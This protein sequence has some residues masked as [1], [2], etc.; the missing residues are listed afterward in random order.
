VDEASERVPRF[1]EERFRELYDETVTEA[2]GVARAI[3]R[4]DDDAQDAVQDAYAVLARYWS[5]GRLRDP[6]RRLLFRVLQRSAIDALRARVRREPRV[7]EVS[8]TAPGSVALP[9]ERALRRLRANDAALL[10]AQAL[11]GLSYEE[12]AAMQRMSVAAVRSRLYRIR[13]ELARRY[14]EEGGEW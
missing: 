11:M 10:I 5:E 1:S 4:R 2:L 3:C 8:R 13:R 12:L 14:E 7:M 9:L 6:P